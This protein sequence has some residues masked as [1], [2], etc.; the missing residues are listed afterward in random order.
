MLPYREV[1]NIIKA[2]ISDKELKGYIR[3][4]IRIGRATVSVVPPEL[5]PDGLKVILRGLLNAHIME[6]NHFWIWPRWVIEQSD[7]E[8]PAF[9]PSA[10]NLLKH[11]LTNRNWTIIGVPGGRHE[12]MVDRDGILTP[13]SNGWSLEGW[14]YNGDRLYTPS[15]VNKE[16][17]RQGLYDSLPIIKTVLSGEDFNLNMEAW[18]VSLCNVETVVQ[19]YTIINTS[20]KRRDYHLYLAIRPYN[21]AGISPVRELLWIEPDTWLINGKTTIIHSKEPDQ[22]S[23][24]SYRKGDIA[25]KVPFIETFSS[26]KCEAGLA[27]GL[28]AYRISLM[29]KERFST[30]FFCPLY[31][32]PTPLFQ[33][34]RKR[35]DFLKTDRIDISENYREL[36]IKEWKRESEKGIRLNFPDDRLM[37]A[38]ISNKLFLRVFD[39]GKIITPGNLDYHSHWFRDSAYMITALEKMGYHESAQEKLMHYPDFQKRDGYFCSHKGEWDSNGEAIWTMVEHYKMTNNMNFLLSVYPSIRKGVSWIKRMRLKETDSR[40]TA[41]LLPPGFSAE[42]LG[43]N[44]YYYWDNFWSVAGINAAAYAA[45]A[46]K[47]ER[48]KGDYDSLSM[49]Y[50]RNIEQSLMRV[51]EKIGDF[52]PASPFRNMD[53][54]AISSLCSIYPLQIFST[55]DTRVKNTVDFLLQYLKDGVF[56][57]NIVHSGYNAYLSAQLAQC[58]LYRGD[59]GFYRIIEGLLKIATQTFTWPEAIHPKTYGG[60]MGDGHHGWAAAEILHLVRNIFI[61]ELWDSLLLCR[62]VHPSWLKEG[63]RI[64]VEDAPTKFGPISFQIEIDKGRAVIKIAPLFFRNPKEILLFIPAAIKSI[65]PEK[66]KV[67]ED[68]KYAYLSSKDMEKPIILNFELQK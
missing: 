36:S 62:G 66:I 67:S 22:I 24:R 65:E 45:E 57:H 18:I 58:M 3:S 20:D 55:D 37:N 23:C 11:N 27:T 40:R 39:D 31:S 29:P 51:K 68:R 49:D 19:N 52:L 21:P 48:D 15:T 16:N 64:A 32:K 34:L 60:C 44:D 25:I 50:L 47:I 33:S 35:E 13:L 43:P 14:V 59:F 10:A 6:S 54:A 42:H 17:I 41:G 4:L 30:H 28:S 46:L 8:S 26:V 56:F 9:I 5:I 63:N 1:L 61:L 53:S 12:A 38:F 2:F 7:R